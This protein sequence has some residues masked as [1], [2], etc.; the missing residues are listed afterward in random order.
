MIV[1]CL[2]Q[3]IED[4]EKE[5]QTEAVIKSFSAYWF[6]HFFPFDLLYEETRVLFSDK[7]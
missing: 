1:K 2:Y 4:S 5:L 7:R 6:S 3:D